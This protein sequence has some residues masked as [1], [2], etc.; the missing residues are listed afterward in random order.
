MP[1]EPTLDEQLAASR[2]VWERLYRKCWHDWR[3]DGLPFGDGPGDCVNVQCWKCKCGE[4][5]AT[6]EADGPPFVARN[7]CADFNAAM[8]VLQAMLKGAH[9]LRPRFWKEL[10]TYTGVDTSLPLLDAIEERF[11]LMRPWH[12][13]LAAAQVLKEEGDASQEAER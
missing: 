12:I 9:Q 11:A 5:T 1:S 10:T 7:L 6:H 3:R 2:V 8:P 13:I 4:M